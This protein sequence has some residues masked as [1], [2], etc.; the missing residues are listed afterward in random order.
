MILYE[1]YLTIT[2]RFGYLK[3][4]PKDE[5][6]VKDAFTG[7]KDAES[8]LKN[9]D[10]VLKAF[11]LWVQEH[12]TWPSHIDLKKMVEPK[13]KNYTVED[14]FYRL[15]EKGTELFYIREWCEANCDI[16]S[17]PSL[18]QWDYDRRTTAQVNSWSEKTD[19]SE[20][21]AMIKFHDHFKKTP[22][23]FE[24]LLQGKLIGGYQALEE[25][26]DVDQGIDL[27]KIGRIE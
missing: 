13:M 2:E 10:I 6:D 18:S 1:N 4:S 21:W 25:P 19:E 27:S 14:V 5:K 12:D 15:H 7:I 20:K 9:D 3:F 8:Y 22:G 16:Y 11:L 23:E 26:K 17:P 24:K